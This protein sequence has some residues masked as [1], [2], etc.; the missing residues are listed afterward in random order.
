MFGKAIFDGR[1]EIPYWTSSQR[2]VNEG[3]LGTQVKQQ[4]QVGTVCAVRVSCCKFGSTFSRIA[5]PPERQWAYLCLNSS[6]TRHSCLEAG[7]TLA[8]DQIYQNYFFKPDRSPGLINK[9]I[10]IQTVHFL[11][12]AGVNPEFL[13]QDL[14]HRPYWRLSCFVHFFMSIVNCLDG[15]SGRPR[16]VASKKG[17]RIWRPQIE[18]SDFVSQPFILYRLHTRFRQIQTQTFLRVIRTSV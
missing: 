15:S 2:N 18:K 8:F 17:L 6:C 13:K 7:V 10:L 9:T 3:E 4:L 11:T 1:T 14:C 16:E 5:Q 12:F